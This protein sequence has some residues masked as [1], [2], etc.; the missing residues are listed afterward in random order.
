ISSHLN[1]DVPFE[2]LGFMAENIEEEE[3]AALEAQETAAQDQ[4]DLGDTTNTP[5]AQ[6]TN[7]N[8]KSTGKASWLERAGLY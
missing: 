6:D 4:P 1:L 7:T 3:A 8:K 2:A 5:V